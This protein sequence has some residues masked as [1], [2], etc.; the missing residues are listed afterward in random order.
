[1][2]RRPSRPQAQAPN[3]GL[4][5]STHGRHC[6]VEDAAGAQ[7]LCYPRGKRLE[8]VVGDRV[9]WKASHDEGVIEAVLP[10]RNLLHRQDAWRSKQF[11]ANLDQ[12][13]ILL[14]AEPDFAEQ[15]LARALIACEAERI[16]PLIA[17][18]KADLAA[19]FARAW[20]RLAAYRDMDYPML[21]IAAGAPGHGP[22]MQAL[23]QQLAGRITLVLGPSG[24]GKSTLINHL[25]P[26]AEAATGELSQA[27][28]S[29]R[30]TTTHTQLYWLDEQ[31]QGALIDS[32]GFQEFGLHHIE[33]AQ[34]P[35]L[36]PD[37]AAH[38][39]HCRFHNCSHLHEPGC[40]VRQALEDPAARPPLTERRYRIYAELMN[41]L[42]RQ[43]G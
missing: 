42:L 31:R 38:A 7:T 34:L 24:A 4:V 12:V 3:E 2:S 25:I 18:N 40:Q 21:A 6:L 1:M 43:P 29:G 11:A 36:M 28:S 35:A 23:E 19:P 26:H 30:H 27:L 17:L 13:L 41:E 8:V 37:I 5:V 32:P 10:R 22:D 39:G 15:Q 20:E 16:R 9:H 33:P 14:A